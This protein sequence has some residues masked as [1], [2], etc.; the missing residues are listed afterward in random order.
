M[1]DRAQ[2]PA[3]G[4]VEKIELLRA[5]PIVLANGLKV[6]SIDGGEQD[7]VRIEFIFA[8]IA[9]DSKKPLQAFA[10]NTMLNDG[11]SE[12]NSSEIADRVDYYGSFLQTD[13]T[14]YF[15]FNIST[16]GVG[17]IG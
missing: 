3:F 8:N 16:G 14:N 13:Y 11:T 1:I 9:Y 10:C 4:Q 2:A 17:Y 15:R 6:F 7:L 5:K 12:L